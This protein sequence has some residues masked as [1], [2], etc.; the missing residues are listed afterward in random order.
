MATIALY[1]NKINQMP[2]L[3][4]DVK[5]SVIDYKSE[6]SAL[7]TKSLSINKSV[8][9]LDVVMS[10]IQTS[11]QTQE[12]KIA[13]LDTFNRNIEQ[14]ISDVACV[15]SD[16]A[17]VVKKRKDE[18]YKDYSYLKPDCEKGWLENKLD[19]AAEWCK[20]TWE[21]AVDFLQAAGVFQMITSALEILGGIAA[22]VVGV[23]SLVGTLGLSTPASI[24][25]II[26][27]IAL[28][29]HGSSGFQEGLETYKG[30][31]N[32]RNWLKDLV[33][34]TAYNIIGIG[35]MVITSFALGGPIGLLSMGVGMLTGEGTKY[36]AIE[37]FGVKP[38]WA[39]YIGLGTSLAVGWSTYKGLNAKF[40]SLGQKFVLKDGWNNLWSKSGGKSYSGNRNP[41][42]D[43]TNKKGNSTLQ[44]HFNRHGS[45]FSSPEAYRSSASN[46]LEKPPT[47]TTQSFVTNEGT[48]FRYDSLT[49]EFGIMNNY[50]GVSTY[51]KPPTGITYWLEQVSKYA[52]E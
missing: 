10:S 9:D 19:K 24:A 49:N 14:F 31:E 27:G 47:S 4:T 30:Y 18:F 41:E 17:E 11:T 5:K 15:D 34:E 8:C 43:F 42:A 33:G 23:L 45:D 36:I 35:G 25:A 20:K 39:D 13:S 6:L 38:V 50:G 46:F 1:A 28:I 32:A 37:K 3:I 48:Y 22:I 12:Q 21:A 16:V 40:P 2:G 7:R 51:Y 52:P 26:G 44:D 29:A